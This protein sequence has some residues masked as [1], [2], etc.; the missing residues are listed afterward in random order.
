MINA[1]QV[2]RRALRARMHKTPEFTSNRQME[3]PS[4]QSNMKSNQKS[5]GFSRLS[6]SL[7]FVPLAASWDPILDPDEKSDVQMRPH[8]IQ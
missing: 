6:G 2:V 8:K 5:L 4:P 7:L 1:A 3:H